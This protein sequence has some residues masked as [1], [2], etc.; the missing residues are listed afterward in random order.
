MFSLSFFLEI[1]IVPVV[2]FFI[3][4]NNY[5]YCQTENTDLL[6]VTNKLYHIKLYRVHLAMNVVRTQNFSGDR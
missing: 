4:Q 6:Q 2:F 3:Q 1:F 5:M